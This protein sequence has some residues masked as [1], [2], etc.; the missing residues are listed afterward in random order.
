[1]LAVDDVVQIVAAVR[2]GEGAKTVLVERLG[3]LGGVAPVEVPLGVI[4]RQVQVADL[5]R[6]QGRLG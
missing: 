2:H 5:D 4:T 6:L 3:D 1:M